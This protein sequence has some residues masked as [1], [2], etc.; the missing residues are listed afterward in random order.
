M[1]HAGTHREAGDKAKPRWK[2]Q[3]WS[4]SAVILQ[5]KMLRLAGVKSDILNEPSP[6][7]QGWDDILT[8]LCAK[9]KIQSSS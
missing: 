2:P 4:V 7:R 9:K 3:T 5:I 1:A 6:L 8:R